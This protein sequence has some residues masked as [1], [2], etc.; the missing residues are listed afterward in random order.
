MSAG[1]LALS[2]ALELRKLQ[3]AVMSA[4]IVAPASPTIPE[5]ARVAGDLQTLLDKRLRPGTP[6]W[7]A[8]MWLEARCHDRIAELAAGKAGA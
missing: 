6:E 8:A 2:R 7:V 1:P 4:R 5:L 3:A